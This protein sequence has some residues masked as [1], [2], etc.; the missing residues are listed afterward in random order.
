MSFYKNHVATRL[1]DLMCANQ[2]LNKWRAR[3]VEGL[4]GTVLEIAFGA[5]RNLALYPPEVTE[6]VAVEPSSIMR[7][8][9]AKKIVASPISVRWGGLNGEHLDLADNSVDHAVVTF[10]LC[11]IPDPL[12]ALREMHRVVRPGGEL[13]ALEH[14]LAPDDSVRRWQHRLNGFQQRWADG[15]QLIRDPVELA[16]EAGWNVI[17]A[18]RKYSPGPKPLSYFSS[19]RAV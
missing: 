4:S 9:A 15:C 1:V 13:R 19:F 6:V 2:G 7:E 10:A 8:R 5:G 3:C 11:T 12:A 17:F 18:F 16:S 14:G